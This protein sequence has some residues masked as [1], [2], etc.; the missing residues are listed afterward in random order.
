MGP[1][2]ASPGEEYWAALTQWKTAG[3]LGDSCCIDHIRT[4]IDAFLDFVPIQSVVKN[5][6]GEAS[7]VMGRSCV[8]IS[9]P[10]NKGESQCE[11]KNALY[12][13]DYSSNLL[14]VSQWFLGLRI[15][16]EEGK[17]KFDQVRYI[18]TMLDRF[19]LRQC[20]PSRTRAD[21]N[22]KIQ[23]TENG[24]EE[25]DQRIYRKLVKSL[26]YL[27]KQTRPDTIFT[28]TILSSHMNAVQPHYY[29]KLNGQGTALSWGGNTRIEGGNNQNCFDGNKLYII[30]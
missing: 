16:R 22:I 3:L 27:A 25:V 29:F 28:V 14:S 7:R 19:Q 15:R 24:D 20:K 1:A 4:N 30:S 12:V 13:P 6:N 9:M 26:L 5:P 11:L 8:K 21:L 17:V 10:S 23:N 2:L 18:E